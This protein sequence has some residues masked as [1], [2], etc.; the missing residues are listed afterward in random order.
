MTLKRIVMTR[1]I[2]F[3]KNLST[4]EIKI[5]CSKEPL[6]RA[7]N[8]WR[9][10]KED[11]THKHKLLYIAEGDFDLEAEI[12]ASLSEKWSRKEWYWLNSK[13]INKIAS[14][15]DLELIKP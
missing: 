10:R 5:G 2:Y 13:D 11:K 6:K 3:L 14:I 9:D 4:K 12:Q 8:V 7:S 15:F 1:Y